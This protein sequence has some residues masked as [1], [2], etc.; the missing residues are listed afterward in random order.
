MSTQNSANFLDFLHLIEN[1]KTIKRTGWI[2]SNIPN[3]ESIADHMYRMGIMAMAIDDPSIDTNRAVQIAIVHDIAEA[4]VGDITPYDNVSKHEKYQLELTIKRTG[5]INSNIP[6][7]ESIA[8]HMYRMGI[9]A[10]A[11][12]D[13]SIDTN[14]AVQIA[15]VHDIAEAVVG[16]ITP[17]D[18]VS[19]HEKYQLELNGVQKIKQVLGNT[20]FSDKIEELWLEYEQGQTIEARLVKDLD[21]F[22]MITQAYEYEIANGVKLQSFFDST[23]GVF[24]HPTVVLWA[25]ELIKKRNALFL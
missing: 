5:W 14:R 9:M 10:M 21:K 17:Y 19:K 4:V 16:D 1:L 25:E 15:I 12:D 7:P 3:P 2:N 8:D 18:N 22:E 11:I 24:K 6:N 20:N 13:P 23:S